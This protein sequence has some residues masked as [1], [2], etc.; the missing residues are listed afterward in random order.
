MVAKFLKDSVIRVQ[1]SMNEWMDCVFVVSKED[2]EKAHEVLSKAWD[3]FFG[4]M[5]TAGAMV[6]TW[7]PKW[8]KQ[9]LRLMRTMLTQTNRR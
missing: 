8:L 9:G 2:E 6:I 5:E 3:R 1:S 7:K 4:K